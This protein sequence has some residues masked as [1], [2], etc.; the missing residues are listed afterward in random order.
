MR[1]YIQYTT[2]RRCVPPLHTSSLKYC[3]TALGYMFAQEN[4]LI[5]LCYDIRATLGTT[6]V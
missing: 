1:T 5:L 4:V 3:I 6:A 2:T